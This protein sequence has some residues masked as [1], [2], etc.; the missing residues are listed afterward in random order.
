MNKLNIFTLEESTYIMQFNLCLP[1]LT[2]GKKIEP[3]IGESF[4]KTN[5]DFPTKFSIISHT[6]T[7]EWTICFLGIG[8]NFYIKDYL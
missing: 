7:L 5:I 4:Q 8:F 1:S 2:I 6:S 3:D